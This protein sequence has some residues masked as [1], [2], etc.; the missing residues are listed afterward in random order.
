MF[1]TLA[2]YDRFGRL[3]CG[4]EHLAKDCLEY[5]VFEKHLSNIYGKWRIHGKVLPDWMP[6]RQVMLRTMRKPEAP[7]VLP[8]PEELENKVATA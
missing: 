4:S 6:D 7:E 5:V 8:E 2:I 1:Q 3:Q